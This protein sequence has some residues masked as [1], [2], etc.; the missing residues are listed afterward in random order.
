[1]TQNKQEVFISRLLG[2]ADT[3][4]RQRGNR[5]SILWE[6][7]RRYTQM[8]AIT[9]LEMLRTTTTSSQD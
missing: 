7:G 5:A 3:R 8:Q 2:I 9:K 6:P 4:Y 1:M